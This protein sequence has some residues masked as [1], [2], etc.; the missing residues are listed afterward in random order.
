MIFCWFSSA[1]RFSYK[2]LFC[3]FLSSI[4]CWSFLSSSNCFCFSSNSLFLTSTS[5]YLTERISTEF[6]WCE[7]CIIYCKFCS[8]FCFLSR[9][10]SSS[11][12]FCRKASFCTNS[13]WILSSLSFSYL[14]LSFSRA[15]SA[16]FFIAS[17]R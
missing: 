10:S 11:I 12:C 2:I 13:S 3:N 4:S 17:W 14:I 8:S 6:Y 15:A 1:M 5:S 9:S 16:F 7:V